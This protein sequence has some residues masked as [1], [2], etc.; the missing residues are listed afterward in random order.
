LQ[1]KSKCEREAELESEVMRLK[2]EV[3]DLRGLLASKAKDEL[4]N[5]KKKKQK[6]TK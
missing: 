2:S 4:G 1:A 5:E 3:A 6:M